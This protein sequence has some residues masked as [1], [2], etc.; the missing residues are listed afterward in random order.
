MAVSRTEWVWMRMASQASWGNSASEALAAS[1]PPR[2]IRGRA[3]WNMQMQP[4]PS[5]SAFGATRLA[6]LTP[7]S[8]KLSHCSQA[9]K[10]GWVP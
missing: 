9:Y 5:N 8:S 4:I 2:P 3:A 1:A 6:P 10:G 7:N